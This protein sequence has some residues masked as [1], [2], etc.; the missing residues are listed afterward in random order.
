MA[1]DQKLPEAKSGISSRG[2]APEHRFTSHLPGAGVS[3]N[4]PLSGLS[5]GSA[6]PEAPSSGWSGALASGSGV[7]REAAQ[8]RPQVRECV[9]FLSRGTVTKK[10]LM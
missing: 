6:E 4:V 2:Q 8:M 3:G 1:E 7:L 10:F 5:E 9:C